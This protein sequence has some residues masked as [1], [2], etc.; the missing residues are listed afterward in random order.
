MY[1]T[2]IEVPIE[3]RNRTVG[4]LMDHLESIIVCEEGSVVDRG[5]QGEIL[6]RG[7]SVMRGYWAEDSKLRN[8]YMTNGWYRTGYIFK[9][10]F[11]DF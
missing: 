6:I 5:Q 11:Y 7:Y 2:H 4:H 10:V 8:S 1:C 9:I 3:E